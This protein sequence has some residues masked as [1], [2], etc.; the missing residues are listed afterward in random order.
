MNKLGRKRCA[1]QWWPRNYILAMGGPAMLTGIVKSLRYEFLCYWRINLMWHILS[2]DT[3][4]NNQLYRNQ[5][6]ALKMIYQLRRKLD[7]FECP[8]LVHQDNALPCRTYLTQ[9][10][11]TETHCWKILPLPPYWLQPRFLPII[12]SFLS[13]NF[14]GGVPHKWRRGRGCS[15]G[16]FES[17][18]EKISFIDSR[19]VASEATLLHE[20]VAS[21]SF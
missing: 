5:L 21:E 4:F 13:K 18:K 10:Q 8:M 2:F 16:Y 19:R 1:R 7:H 20:S 15:I 9:N 14:L 11:I 17:M 12:T 3:S 6:S